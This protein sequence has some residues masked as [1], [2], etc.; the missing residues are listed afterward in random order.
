M[1]SMV[2][3]GAASLAEFRGGGGGLVTDTAGVRATGIKEGAVGVSSSVVTSCGVA[4][5]H[6]GRATAGAAGATATTAIL[7]V[8]KTPPKQLITGDEDN[9]T[10][11]ISVVLGKS[12][13]ALF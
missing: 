6:R 3:C 11:L 7:A 2:V 12:F 13:I 4:G 8:W 5:G 1:R 10:R 9:H